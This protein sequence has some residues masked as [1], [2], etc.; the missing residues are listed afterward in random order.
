[1]EVYKVLA[2]SRIYLR[3]WL[4]PSRTLSDTMIN[5]FVQFFAAFILYSLKSNN[6]SVPE[7]KC[8]NFIQ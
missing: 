1:M 7:K 2:R 8:E 3:E 6:S 4:T 5:N